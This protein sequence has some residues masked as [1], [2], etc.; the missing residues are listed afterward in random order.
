MK[1]SR[2]VFVFVLAVS[3]VQF[4]AARSRS[5]E[6]PAQP[7]VQTA[8]SAV[9]SGVYR[10]RP[11]ATASRTEQAISA[12]W[13]ASRPVYTGSPYAE[14]PS[15]RAPY[16]PGRLADGFVR[17]GL[18]M[19]NFVRYLAGFP[20]D[21]PLDTNYTDRCQKGVVLLAAVN[22]VAHHV[23]RPADMPEPF[24]VAADIGTRNSDI[25]WGRKTLSDA[26]IKWMWDS[27]TANLAMIG[28]RRW[29]LDADM[30]ATGFGYYEKYSAVYV[31]DYSTPRQ[32]DAV[33]DPACDFASWPAAGHFPS[34][35][36][37][38][39]AAWTVIL[40]SDGR[41][42]AGSPADFTVTLTRASDGKVWRLDASDNTVTESGEYF[43]YN[44]KIGC[45]AFIFRPDTA[46]ARYTAGEIYEVKIEGL[47]EA[48][49][50]PALID[51]KVEFFDL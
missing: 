45:Y 31:I 36:F 14:M 15:I 8:V 4:A 6:A 7:S 24:Y 5:D 43:N 1:I 12:V 3:A 2:I 37:T 40:R 25:I 21:I 51:Y 26:V 18:N 48:D 28:H 17:D 47:K 23:D 42:L 9:P 22:K 20:S 46:S 44:E 27:D 19:L 33:W 32:L 29:I 10:C 41:F 35:F 49:G 50:T 39:T 13:A 38:N 16:S 30:S 34:S 11:L